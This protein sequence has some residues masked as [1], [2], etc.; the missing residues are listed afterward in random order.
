MSIAAFL[1]SHRGRRLRL[2]V[3]LALIAAI[4]AGMAYGKGKPSTANL[5]TGPITVEAKPLAGFDRVAREKTKFGKLSWRG[6]LVL[7]SPS[8]YFGGWSGLALDPDG[9]GYFA[10][11]D[12]GLWMSGKLSYD[13]KGAP[14][15]MADVRVGA[16]QSKEGDPLSRKKDSDSEGLA[17]ASGNVENGTALISF[18]RKH[19]IGRY[20]IK[21]GELSPARGKVALPKSARDMPDNG[22]F[23][24]IAVLQGGA[25]KGKL[26][27]FSERLRD[28]NGNY[29]GWIWLDKDRPR[30]FFMTNDGD[31]DITDAAPLPDG[32]L[33]VLERRF[34]FSE[35]VSMRLRH[36]KAGELRRG[37]VIDA[38]ILVASD[39]S[40]EIDNMEGL[41]THQGPG[42]EVIIT[43]ISD[44]NYNHTLQRT[45]LL[46]FSISQADLDAKQGGSKAD[47]R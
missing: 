20:D 43:M 34:R 19:R 33:L 8:E 37:R 2:P 1:K 29:I 46:Q 15:G 30:T 16:I 47:G 44:D 4:G 45:L 14:S 36:I 23:E 28:D 40:K 24:A 25:N 26:V 3:G 13:D 6:G 17:I 10:I 22:G 12:A 18:E 5:V 32:S 7:T 11:S 9:K 21:N 27:A 42:G 35:G 31:Y 38:D 39:G 41:A